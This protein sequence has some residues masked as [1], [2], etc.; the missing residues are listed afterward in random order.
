[1]KTWGEVR[2][3]NATRLVAELDANARL[4]FKMPHSVPMAIV[5]EG[6]IE[7]MIKQKVFIQAVVDYLNDKTDTTAHERLLLQMAKEVK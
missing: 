7:T 4:H 6:D 2:T 1:M 3:L 5:P